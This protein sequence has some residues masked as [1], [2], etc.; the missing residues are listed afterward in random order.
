MKHITDVSELQ[1]HNTAIALGKFDGIHRGHRMLL[2][3]VKNWQR[4]GLT[5]VMFTFS[6]AGSRLG[7][8]KRIDSRDEKFR[9]AEAVGIDILLEYPFTKGFSAMEPESFVAEV[10]I[11]QLGV[12]AVAVGTDFRFGRNRSGDA[13]LLVSLGERYGFRVMVFDKLMENQNE[14]SSSLI[15]SEIEAGHMEQVYSYMGQGY[16]VWGEVVHG[17]ALG[18]SIGIPTANQWIAPEKLLPPFGVYAARILWKDRIYYGISN[19]GCKPTVSEDQLVGLETYIFNFQQDIYGE[20]I[21]V[22]LLHFIRPE[23]KF[24]SVEELVE[25]MQEDIAKAEKWLKNWIVE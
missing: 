23:R 5:G 15:R 8:Q 3:Q 25:Q 2:E 12:K 24:Q 10:L 17:R 11:K 6:E 1:L 22:E 18:S 4:Q 20:W 7:V 9:K 13:D 16:S 14:I 19:L 21:E